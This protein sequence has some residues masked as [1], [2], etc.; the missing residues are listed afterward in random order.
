MQKKLKYSNQKE[1]SC[2][3]WCRK[4][5]KQQVKPAF[6]SPLVDP[7]CQ[8]LFVHLCFFPLTW[9]VLFVPLCAAQYTKKGTQRAHCCLRL[10][11]PIKHLATGNVAQD[12]SGKSTHIHKH[13]HTHTHT[14]THV[15]TNACTHTHA[16]TNPHAHTHKNKRTHACTN[17]HADSHTLTDT[18]SSG[19]G[20]V[21]HFTCQSD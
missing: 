4:A 20:K 2:Q 17:P 13:I 8:S 21:K 5:G 9:S 15:C 12:M 18:H 14:H 19:R 6:S 1:H 16:G 3:A 11:R 10:T 7:A